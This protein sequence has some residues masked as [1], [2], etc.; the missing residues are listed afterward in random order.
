[1]RGAHRGS[2]GRAQDRL[3]ARLGA[4]RRGRG[5]GPRP[6]RGDPHRVRRD[7]HGGGRP[8]RQPG[9]QVDESA[10]QPRART[11]LSELRERRVL[12]GALEAEGYG[13]SAPIADNDTAEG[14]EINRRIEFR[15]LRPAPEAEA[16]AQTALA[17]DAESD[18]SGPQADDG[19]A[20]RNADEQD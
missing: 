8:H 3:R 7:P 4:G 17:P 10:T 16:E 15:L 13:E 9:A 20:G 19:D 14:R 2:A 12:T 6:D 11:V 1:M 18:D 5:K